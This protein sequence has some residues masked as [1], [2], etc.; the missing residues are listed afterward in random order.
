MKKHIYLLIL[1][2]SSCAVL[3]AQTQ[4]E[5]KTQIDAASAALAKKD[6]RNVDKSLNQAL[7]AL[8]KMAGKEI[9]KMM[10]LELAGLKSLPEKELIQ[11]GSS[12]MAPGS[13]IQR[14]YSSADASKIVNMTVRPFSPE[15]S[16]VSM[17]IANPVYLKSD[18]KLTEKLVTVNGRKAILKIN[19]ELNQAEVLIVSGNTL[20]SIES[21]GTNFSEAE[22]IAMASKIEIG[23]ME[24]LLK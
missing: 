7:S 24:T 21:S 9:V 18:D 13:L 20:Y 5:V 12:V 11:V 4:A 19:A 3:T 17:Y 15:L 10:P 14:T 23:K 6:L 22:L 2:V 1:G 16:S 8:A